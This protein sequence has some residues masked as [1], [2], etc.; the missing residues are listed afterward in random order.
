MDVFFFPPYLF[1]WLFI[2]SRK[3]QT[4]LVGWTCH[5]APNGCHFLCSLKR[6][7][8]AI[9]LLA[10]CLAPWAVRRLFLLAKGAPGWAAEPQ[11]GSW[12]LW[13][14]HSA[15]MSS[16][17]LPSLFLGSE[18][19][20]PDPADFWFWFFFSQ[21]VQVQ[22]WTPG[23]AS[24]GTVISR[25][26]LSD[27]SSLVNIICKEHKSHADCT[28]PGDV[29]IE[30]FSFHNV[31]RK[32]MNHKHQ[33]PWLGHG[34]S[35]SLSLSKET[36]GSEPW[37]LWARGI[38][39][40]PPG[41]LGWTLVLLHGIQ[42]PGWAR[43]R[44]PSIPQGHRVWFSLSQTHKTTASKAHNRDKGWRLKELSACFTGI[45]K[46]LCNCKHIKVWVSPAFGGKANPMVDRYSE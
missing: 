20:P 6:S 24:S 44:V 8:L 15:A 40:L 46:R 14:L 22:S 23:S 16:H 4:S 25:G 32:E 31:L 7:S 38:L 5:H 19:T 2:D 21:K 9:S 39:S 37:I 43:R 45:Q 10:H 33:S 35:V 28:H 12:D 36:F 13:A 29:P 42:S 26:T 34:A 1:P 27:F 30:H 17:F 18:T 11:E 3:A 41:A